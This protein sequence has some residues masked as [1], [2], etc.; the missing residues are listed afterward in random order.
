MIRRGTPA[1][2][3]EGSTP[4]DWAK[5]LCKHQELVRM[6]EV[7]AGLPFLMRTE[8]F[9]PLLEAMRLRCREIERIIQS[10]S[11]RRIH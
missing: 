9:L 1:A 6:L 8:S 5:T 11:V 4:E 3:P 7:F 10:D 2:E